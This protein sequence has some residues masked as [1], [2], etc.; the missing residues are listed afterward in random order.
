VGRR[1]VLDWRDVGAS[2]GAATIE[3]RW[4]TLVIR[5]IIGRVGRVGVSVRVNGI[6]DGVPVRPRIVPIAAGVTMAVVNRSMRDS[7]RRSRARSRKKAEH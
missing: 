7:V 2:A 4:P 1:H 3:D 6:G 5:V